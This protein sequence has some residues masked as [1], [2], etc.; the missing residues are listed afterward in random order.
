[1]GIARSAVEEFLRDISTDLRWDVLLVQ[2]LAG[3]MGS[4][5][6]KTADGHYVFATAPGE[7]RRRS[8]IVVHK[9][10]SQFIVEGSFRDLGRAASLDVTWGHWHVRLITAHLHAGNSKEDYEQS[11]EMAEGLLSLPLGG[12]I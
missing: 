5:N 11:L 10:A 4:M 3:H 7:G 9:D 6:C 8:A 12:A 2:E 1:M